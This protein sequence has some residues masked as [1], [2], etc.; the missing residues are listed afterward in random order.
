[1]HGNGLIMEE[2]RNIEELFKVIDSGNNCNNNFDQE[3]FQLKNLIDALQFENENQTK[4]YHYSSKY[5]G[6]SINLG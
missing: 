2:V 3:F 1:M 4:Y 5:Y 6:G